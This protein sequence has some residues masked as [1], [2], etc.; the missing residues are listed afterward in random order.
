MADLS[1]PPLAGNG[2]VAAVRF[3]PKP[4]AKDGRRR[5][6]AALRRSVSS[7][8]IIMTGLATGPA[9]AGGGA[10]GNGVSSSPPFGIGGAGGS[11]SG[12]VT[13]GLPG[14]AGN[15]NS[16]IIIVGGGGTG[17]AGIYAPDYPCGLG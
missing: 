14:T 13:D 3:G 8:A 17:G 4:R 9:W 15:D 1:F 2:P 10:G 16:G 12:S 7:L 5:G 6:H 11:T